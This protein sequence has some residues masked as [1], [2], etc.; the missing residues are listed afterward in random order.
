MKEFCSQTG[1]DSCPPGPRGTQGFKGDTGDRGLPGV[2]GPRGPPGLPGNT[3]SN[4]GIGMQGR[5]GLFV[6]PDCAL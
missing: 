6:L 5:P 1:G 2:P 4:R 3:G